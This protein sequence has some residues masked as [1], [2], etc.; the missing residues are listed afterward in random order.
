MDGGREYRLRRS[1][2]VYAHALCCARCVYLV[3]V[4]E[5]SLN[6]AVN[7]SYTLDTTE[8]RKLT[9]ACLSESI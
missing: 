4:L 6:D 9:R 1:G 8:V 2:A 3:T 7:L 5:I